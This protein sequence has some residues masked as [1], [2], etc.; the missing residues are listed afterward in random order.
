MHIE[1]CKKL[2][3]LSDICSLLCSFTI[4]KWVD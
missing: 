1:D 2:T 3:T 4:T